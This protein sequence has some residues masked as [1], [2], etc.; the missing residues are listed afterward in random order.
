MS[1][2]A[3]GRGV[4]R[5]ESHSVMRNRFFFDPADPVFADHFPGCPVIPGSLLLDCFGKTAG[6]AARERLKPVSIRNARFLR[7]GR[8]GWVD[9]EVVRAEGRGG[10]VVY[11]CRAEQEGETLCSAMLHCEAVGEGLM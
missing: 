5:D 10:E 3:E 9:I 1:K 7:F 4:N 11:S 2:C 8:P 6:R